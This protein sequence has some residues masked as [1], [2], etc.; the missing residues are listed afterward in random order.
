MAS[1]RK[2]EDIEASGRGASKKQ[3]TA[4]NHG[5]QFKDSEQK[6]RYKS[7]ISRTISPCRIHGPSHNFQYEWRVNNANFLI[8]LPNSDITNPKVVENFY[9]GTNPQVHNDGD[10]GGDEE[11]IGEGGRP[12]D[13][14]REDDV[15]RGTTESRLGKGERIFDGLSLGA[16]E[17]DLELIR[18]ENRKIRRQNMSPQSQKLGTARASIGTA[19]PPSRI[20]F[21]AFA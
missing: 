1:K 16:K 2:G 15:L 21:A 8:I 4:R 5:I 9:V 3:S 6:N 12:S 13:F 18:Y 7:L 14:L 10:D 19:V 11:E 20:A 17:R